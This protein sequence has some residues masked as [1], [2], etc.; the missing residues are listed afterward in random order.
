MNIHL[1]KIINAQIIIF[2]LILVILSWGQM[3][4]WDLLQPIAMTDRY[5]L[6][7]SLYPDLELAIPTGV[8]SYFPGVTVIA[9][10]VKNIVP[11][12]LLVYSMHLIAVLV[13]LSFCSLNF[14]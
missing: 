1:N 12:N 10:M 9:L 2:V 6:L 5:S 14:Y 4:R 3:A 11:N 7:G 8:S 13:L